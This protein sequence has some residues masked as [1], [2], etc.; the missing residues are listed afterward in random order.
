MN[1]KKDNA[2]RLDTNSKRSDSFVS[3]EWQEESASERSDSAYRDLEERTSQLI[4]SWDTTPRNYQEA[5][6]VFV[7]I[8]KNQR[9]ASVAST[10]TEEG[11]A[12]YEKSKQSIDQQAKN[13]A[14][15][16]L[17]AILK[18]NVVYPHD[19]VRA[20]KTLA[21]LGEEHISEKKARRL[22]KHLVDLNNKTESK[23]ERTSWQKFTHE[24]NKIKEKCKDMLAGY[25]REE[26][27][28]KLRDILKLPNTSAPES[29]LKQNEK[30][31]TTSPTTSSRTSIHLG[32]VR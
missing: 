8:A 30:S 25:N 23:P 32:R 21:I 19:V 4:D 9:S 31:T 7:G 18:K 14:K 6:K 17:Q 15:E 1:P 2:T 28:L 22:S 11:I 24:L 12:D 29:K 27:E 5:V 13:L 26:T 20:V 3:V 16:N 10:T